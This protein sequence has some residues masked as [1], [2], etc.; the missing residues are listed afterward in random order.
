M[1]SIPFSRLLGSLVGLALFSLGTP[2]VSAQS[3]A[4][5]YTF[6]SFA[7]GASGSRGSADGEGAA[8]RFSGPGGMAI[9]GGGNLFVADSSN[10][11]IRK[12]TPAGNTTTVA[13][14]AGQ[15]GTSDGLGSTARFDR[16]SGVAVDG[17]GNLY[18]AD[19]NNNAIRKVSPTGAVTTLAGLAAP[20]PPQSVD[21]TGSAARIGYPNG[22]AVDGAGTVYVTSEQTI[23]R[24]TPAGVVTTLAGLFQRGGSLDGAGS[25]ARFENPYG[26]AVDRAGTTFVTSSQTIRKVT[27]AGVVTTFAGNGQANGETV[28]GTGSAARLFSVR[29]MTI[30]ASGN[31]YV[32]NGNAIRKITPAGVVTTIAGGENGGNVD[33]VGSAVRFDSP[34]GIVVDAAGIVYVADTFNHR[35]RKG[36]PAPVGTSSDPGRLINLSVLTGISSVGEDFTMGYVVGGTGT[37]GV[38]PLVIRAAG[39][40]LGALGVSSTLDDPKLELFAGSSKTGENDNWG[41]SSQLTAAL[42]AV[43]AFAYTGP[44]SKDAAITASITTSDN[45]VKVSAAGSGTGQVIAEIYDATPGTAFTATSPRLINVSVRK[46]IGSGLT[47]GFVVGGS[48]PAK[49]L[50]RGVGPSLGAFGVSGTVADPQLTLYNSSSAKIGENNDWAGSAELTTAFASAGAF[51]LPATSKDAALLV[52]LPPGN[53][54]AQ[55]T[56]VNG[57]TGVALVEVYEAP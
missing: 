22:I 43:G 47:M 10:H 3:G 55:V 26:I 36:I 32:T 57:T 44:N 49:V 41:G 15:N 52:T 19:Q 30:D 31:I 7:G 9:D 12:I 27:P 25:A 4:V 34:S 21:G 24:I 14:L 54:T 53:Y 5:A 48:T 38:K 33:G 39:P 8:A 45:S 23:R 18:V 37:S 40:S 29:A 17:A 51:A 2:L 16:P 56:G 11:T 20:G 6:S 46:D 28:D 1:N 13:G 42:A 35:I 50:V